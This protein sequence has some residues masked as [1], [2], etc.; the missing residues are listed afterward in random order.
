MY[1]PSKTC[2]DPKENYSCILQEIQLCTPAVATSI[3]NKYPTLQSL[4]QMY[5]STNK[6]EGEQLLTNLDVSYFYHFI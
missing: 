5:T 1:K 2:V 6:A 4:H 3:I